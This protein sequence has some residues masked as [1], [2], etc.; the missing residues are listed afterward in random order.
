M[1]NKVLEVQKKQE[2]AGTKDAEAAPA[3]ESKRSE[4]MRAVEASWSAIRVQRPMVLVAWAVLAAVLMVPYAEP[5]WG[6]VQRWWR[7]PDYQHGFL[8]PLF[9]IYLLWHRRS[10]IRRID[11]KGSWWGLVPLVAAALLRWGSAYFYH[12]LLDPMSIVPC[13]AGLVLFVGGWRALHWSWPAVFFLA[14]MIPAPGFVAELFSHPLQRVGTIASTYIIQTLG[15]PAIAQGNVIQLSNAQI[16]VVEAC[17]GLRMMMLFVTVC[18]G[19]AFLMKTSWVEK[20][21][22]I[23]SAAP[24]AVA[25]N[26]FRIT[27]TSVLHHFAS[28]ELADKIFHDLAGWLMMPVALMLLWVELAIVTRIVIEPEAH[29]PV[30]VGAAARRGNA[31]GG[32]STGSQTKRRHSKKRKRRK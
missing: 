24:I 2:P 13:L 16:G 12:Q 8:V 6:I 18:T 14:F 22:V 4:W 19:A 17:S 10:M 26:V 31:N 30:T 25:A 27:L 7:E 5:M 3:D 9:S 23:V 21:I 11:W 15:I 28:H 32:A 1:P 20:V 29:G